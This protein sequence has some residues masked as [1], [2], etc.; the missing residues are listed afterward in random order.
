MKIAKISNQENNTFKAK[1]KLKKLN[2]KQIQILEEVALATTGAGLAVASAKTAFE[3][4]G[5]F[6][7]PTLATT[8][9]YSAAIGAGGSAAAILDSTKIDDVKKENLLNKTMTAALPLGSAS[10]GGAVSLLNP[11]DYELVSK[12]LATT[13]AGLVSGLALKSNF[14][15]KK[16]KDLPS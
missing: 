14:D 12:S 4:P 15:E 5:E 11:N 10:I 1:M 9:A 6:Y 16:S 3:N 8:S 7:A 13:S 2:P